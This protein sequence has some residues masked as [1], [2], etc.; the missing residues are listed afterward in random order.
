AGDDTYIL[1]LQVTGSGASANVNAFADN[2]TETN[3]TSNGIDS[4]KLRGSAALTNTTTLSLSGEWASI[5]S[6][7]ASAT[8]STKLNILGNANDNILIGNQGSNTIKGGEGNDY[9]YGGGGADIMIGGKGDDTYI[10]DHAGDQVDE[11]FAS[12]AI[13]LV[14]INASGLIGNS[15]SYFSSFSTDGR[16]VLF[17]SMADNLI[18]GD[19]N[20]AQDYFLKDLFTEQLT[21]VSLTASGA[22]AQGIAY[23]DRLG[24]SQFSKDGNYILFTGYY[25]NM[26]PGVSSWDGVQHIYLKNLLTG[27]VKLIDQ[28]NDT[29]GNGDSFSASISSDNRYVLFTSLA[30]NLGTDNSSAHLFLKDLYTDKI[31]V[32]AEKVIYDAKFMPD[33]GSVLFSSSSDSL[34]ANDTN[35]QADVFIKNLETGEVSLISTDSNDMQLHGYSSGGSISSDGRYVAFSSTANFTG[36]NIY[37]KPHIYVKDLQTGTLQVISTDDTGTLA[38]GGSTGNASISSSGRYVVFTSDASNLVNNDTNREP[39]VFIKDIVTG[40]IRMLSY[41]SAQSWVLSN[42]DAFSADEQYIT[43]QTNSDNPALADN[44]GSSDAIIVNNPFITGNDLGID[45]VKSSINY[46]LT[47]YVENLVL[48]GSV[49]INGNGNN[50]DNIITGNIGNNS[51]NGAMG[52]DTLIGGAGNDTLTGGLGAD[53]FV[54]NLADRGT[55]GQPAIDKITD[56]NS[57]EDKLDLR[58]LLVGE[59]NGNI[60]NYL[61]ITTS[62]TAGVTNTEIRISNTGGFTGGNYSAAAENQHI[63]LAGINL[64]AGTNEADLLANLISQNKLVIDA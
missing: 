12:G 42:R 10:V 18:D 62:N 5:E 34:V 61:D 63:T 27:D 44:N 38:N 50:L 55:N 37:Q 49:N 15:I 51:L 30:G 11:S 28:L 54:W 64:L 21:R 39:D 47:D 25:D 1:D 58:D 41:G 23:Q 35:G 46:T 2:I 14:A 36:N 17:G 33:N 8:G 7:D 26:A 57:A 32:L 56:F 48:T 24:D 4:I 3:G 16:Y 60:L 6:L 59:S 53:T 52:K 20:S 22:E 13:H 29:I 43:F 31:E 9:I 19:A 40:Q 45:T